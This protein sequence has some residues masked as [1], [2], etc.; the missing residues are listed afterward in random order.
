MDG[1]RTGRPG[2]IGDRVGESG[3]PACP[4]GLLPPGPR[5]GPASRRTPKDG[6]YVE[7]PHRLNAKP[8]HFVVQFKSALSSR[9]VMTTWSVGSG[10]GDTQ[11]SARSQLTPE[12]VPHKAFRG[13]RGTAS[14]A[15]GRA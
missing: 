8:A 1:R 7:E 6:A 10:R 12:P 13:V 5:R 9:T 15:P 14:V 11:K 3:G 2:V 4:S